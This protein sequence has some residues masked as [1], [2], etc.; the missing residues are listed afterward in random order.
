MLPYHLHY[1]GRCGIRGCVRA[2][3]YMITSASDAKLRKNRLSSF[4]IFV[5]ICI[6]FLISFIESC[7]LC[8]GHRHGWSHGIFQGQFF[9]QSSFTRYL[10]H[11]LEFFRTVSEN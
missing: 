7:G 2:Y 11:Y 4:E 9:I 3:L 10:P 6:C 8:Q 5:A 1:A